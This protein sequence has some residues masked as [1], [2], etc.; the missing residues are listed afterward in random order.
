M[1]TCLG[2]T[3]SDGGLPVSEQHD[4]HP[5]GAWGSGD[6]DG[7][8]LVSQGAQRSATRGRAPPAISSMS[9]ASITGVACVSRVVPVVPR[10]R[11][12]GRILMLPGEPDLIL[13]ITVVDTGHAQ[14]NLRA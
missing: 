2:K 13:D 3:G 8:A 9:A 14:G 12:P 5:Q 11:R 1:R 7:P 10:Q 4:S 6:E